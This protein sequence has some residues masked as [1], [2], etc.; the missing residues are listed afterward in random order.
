MVL[1]GK[2]K[3]KAP[4]KRSVPAGIERAEP[5]PVTAEVPKEEPFQVELQVETY[6]ELMPTP[7][8]SN[9]T[10]TQRDEAPP[11]DSASGAI[12]SRGIGAAGM[13][14]NP[15]PTRHDS[16][17]TSCAGMTDADALSR[18]GTLQAEN[19]PADTPAAAP[20]ADEAGKTDT[21]QHPNEKP[22]PHADQGQEGVAASTKVAEKDA[23]ATT[24]PKETS[25]GHGDSDAPEANQSFESPPNDFTARVHETFTNVKQSLS[26]GYESL[27]SVNVGESFRR[28][29]TGDFTEL[30]PA[31]QCVCGVL[32]E[33]TEFGERALPCIL[34]DHA[35]VDTETREPPMPQIAMIVNTPGGPYVRRIPD[36]LVGDAINMGFITEQEVQRQREEW[37]RNCGR[38]PIEYTPTTSFAAQKATA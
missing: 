8:S 15:P 34:G 13:H 36:E 20:A 3:A 32:N 19:Q 6:E 18:R 4:S 31:E 14:G 33:I 37:E 23:H 29:S 5:P 12:P 30:H 21:Q 28:V 38:I 35:D 1:C 2:N 17:A 9:D 25:Q 24:V 16:T 22:P 10:N 7:R 27:R 26:R 11:A